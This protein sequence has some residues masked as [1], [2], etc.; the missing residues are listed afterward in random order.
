[1]A[2]PFQYDFWGRIYPERTYVTIS[3]SLEFRAKILEKN[4]EITLR[5]SINVAQITVSILSESEIKDIFTVKNIVEDFLYSII[6][7]FGYSQGSAFTIEITGVINQQSGKTI[8]FSVSIPVLIEQVKN[9]E[10]QFSDVINHLLITNDWRLR[11]CLADLCSSIKFSKDSAFLVYRGIESI[12]SYFADKHSI[13][14]K[15]AW[16]KFRE[17]LQIEYSELMFVKDF[18]DPIRHGGLKPISDQDRGKVLMIGWAIVDKY[19]SYRRQEVTF[20]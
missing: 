14:K 9:L 19:I 8:I 16:E 1:M 2:K 10:N 12:Q 20:S 18:A 11:L 15:Q 3:P 4:I 13:E 5:I 6:N 17:E 7:S